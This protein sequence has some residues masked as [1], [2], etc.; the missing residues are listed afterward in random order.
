[1]ILADTGALY[2]LADR[3]DAWYERMRR[4][5]ED[6]PEPW[7]VPASVVTE[8]AFLYAR[9]LGPGAEADFVGSLAAG[10]FP[11]EVLESADYARAADLIRAYADLPLGFVDASIVAMAERLDVG[12]LVTTD[13]RHFTVVRPAHVPRLRLAP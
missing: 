3:R 2:A 6:N 12:T 1:L 8:T 13:R 10:V 7:L 4:Y 5:W 9:R 11:V